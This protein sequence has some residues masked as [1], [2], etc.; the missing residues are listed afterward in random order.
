MARSMFLDIILV[1]PLAPP[2][3][4]NSLERPRGEIKI[5][6]QWGQ[7]SQNLSSV[8]IIEFI[9]FKINYYFL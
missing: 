2:N 1:H 4:Q 7:K 3:K 9:K 6:V 8:K 5:N